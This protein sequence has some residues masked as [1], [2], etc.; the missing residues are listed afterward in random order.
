[1]YNDFNSFHLIF[2]TKEKNTF[3]NTFQDQP[4]AAFGLSQACRNS[5]LFYNK[6][7][8]FKQR[9]EHTFN[10]IWI[11]IIY[12]SF[13]MIQP[14]FIFHH[15]FLFQYCRCNFITKCTQVEVR[16][17]RT[18]IYCFAIANYTKTMNLGC[19]TSWTVAGR[20]RNST[21]SNRHVLD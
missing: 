14:N 1:M 10:A 16:Y 8:I 17:L 4:G 12:S 9:K 11:M 15:C 6:V 7:L 18:I 20:G 5:Q 13:F 3:G 19:S 21:A 2:T